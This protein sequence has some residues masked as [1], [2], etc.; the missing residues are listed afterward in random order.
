MTDVTRSTTQRYSAAEKLLDEA[1]SAMISSQRQQCATPPTDFI[2][3]PDLQRAIIFHGHFC[4]GLAIGY[5]AAML[6]LEYLAEARRPQDGLLA[7]VENNSCAVD[8]IQCLTGCTLGN[9]NFIF[10]NLERHAFTLALVPG[11]T[12]V[13]LCLRSEA[14]GRNHQ[15]DK[16]AWACWLLTA[17]A[18]QVFDVSMTQVELPPDDDHNSLAV[19]E[20]CGQ[21][22]LQSHCHQQDADHPHCPACP[23]EHRRSCGCELAKGSK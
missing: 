21:L 2:A 23:T 3:E 7:I 13:R 15:Q 5:R 8:A 22:F 6:A 11:G 12:A 1:C 20:R 16:E 4:P 9:G 17:P 19:C 10:Q 14:R 18:E